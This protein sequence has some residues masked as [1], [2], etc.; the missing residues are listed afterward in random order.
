MNRCDSCRSLSNCP[1]CGGNITGFHHVGVR[2]TTSRL[3]IPIIDQYVSYDQQPSGIWHYSQGVLLGMQSHRSRPPPTS[4][5]LKY[6]GGPLW[7][8]GYVWQDVYWGTY[9]TKPTSAQWINRLELAVRHIESDTSYSGGLNQ[10]NVGIG[11]IN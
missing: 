7:E 1:V 5:I 6:N 8:N 4:S 2:G 3:R 11:K 10:Y 9:Y